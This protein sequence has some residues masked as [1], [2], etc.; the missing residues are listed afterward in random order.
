MASLLSFFDDLINKFLYKQNKKQGF[1]LQKM[2]KK[3]P[4]IIYNIHKST[5]N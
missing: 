3:L 4:R 2:T 1:R 5:F